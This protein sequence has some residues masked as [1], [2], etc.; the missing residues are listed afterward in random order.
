MTIFWQCYDYQMTSPVQ[1]DIVSGLSLHELVNRSTAFCSLICLPV[2]SIHCAHIWHFWHNNW[3]LLMHQE[4][5]G[6]HL[7]PVILWNIQGIYITCR[8]YKTL[9]IMVNF[10]FDSGRS[11]ECDKGGY[12]WQV[13]VLELNLKLK[14]VNE[15]CLLR[16]IKP[17]A[18][19]E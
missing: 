14:V 13:T 16:F 7:C 2:E 9:H 4:F 3:G 1:W 17:I 8:T 19:T 18:T 12:Y 11:R 15:L 10:M 6:A 5:M